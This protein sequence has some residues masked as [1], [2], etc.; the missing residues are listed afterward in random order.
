VSNRTDIDGPLSPQIVVA[1]GDLDAAIAFY[2]DSLGLRLDMIMPADAPRTAIVSGHG[3]TVRLVVEGE[4]VARP[5]TT[6]AQAFLINRA[7]DGNAWG[8]GRAGMHY[9][10]L[11]PGRLGG[12][13][14]ASHIRIPDGGPVDDYV[15]YHRVKFQMIYCRRGWVRVVYEDQGPP[16]VMQA[17]DCVLQP[18]TIRHRV[19]ESSPGL[20]VIEIACP[21]EHETFRE[22][23]LELP[24]AQSNPQRIFDGQRF[25]HHRAAEAV[26]RS[27]YDERISRRDTDISQATSGIADVRVLRIA[28]SGGHKTEPSRHDGEFLFFAML[29]GR[30]Q[31]RSRLLG[32]HTL[33]TDDVCV[34]P[35]GADYALETEAPCEVLEVKLPAA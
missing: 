10:D 32:A 6:A 3:T 7:A 20:E 5:A 21:A 14:I 26:W 29:D 19:L 12:R 17:G 1:C 35:K 13:F 16:F 2:V 28:P 24:T 33:E 11:I 8:P 31:L 9:R 23:N 30:A 4:D 25:V 22:H 27:T 15:H 34:I 18:P